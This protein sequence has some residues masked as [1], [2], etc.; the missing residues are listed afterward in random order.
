MAALPELPASG[1]DGHK[2]RLVRHVIHPAMTSTVGDLMSHSIVSGDPR[3]S[4][5]EAAAVMR[6]H[7]ISALSVL[8]DG[9]I[10]G[11]I[12]ERDLLRAIAD[13]RDPA[14]THV[15]QYMT[16]SPRTIEASEMATTAAATMIKHRVRHLPVTDKGR[17]VGFLSAR[18][19][20]SLRPFPRQLPI[21]EPW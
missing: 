6:S 17:L 4:L 13:G 7:R 12:T 15:S 18:D 5:V 1:L 14:V 16:H 10:V 9:A 2:M 3:R 20:L 11:I 19:L 8:D 21:G